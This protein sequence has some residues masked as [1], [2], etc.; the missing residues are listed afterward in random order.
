MENYNKE[1]PVQTEIE[2]A[3]PY[4]QNSIFYQL[5]GGTAMKLITVN[6]AAADMF[7]LG[8]FFDLTL[9]PAHDLPQ[10]AQ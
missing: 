3:V 2:L 1:K 9:S 8:K 6:Q 10:A 5:S 7:K 4:D